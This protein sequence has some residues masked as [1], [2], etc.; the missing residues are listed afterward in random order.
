METCLT[1]KSQVGPPDSGV[2]AS[3]QAGECAM[4]NIVNNWQELANVEV[5]SSLEVV[6]CML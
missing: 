5:C 6:R 3:A 4:P 1:S 2:V